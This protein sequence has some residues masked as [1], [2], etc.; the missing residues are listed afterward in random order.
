[1]SNIILNPYKQLVVMFGDDKNIPVIGWEISGLQ[2]RPILPFAYSGAVSV[3]DVRNELVYSG[4]RALSLRKYAE[5][6][7]RE[8]SR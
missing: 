3:F 1:M 7:S 8:A 6:R 4:G 2:I 5:K